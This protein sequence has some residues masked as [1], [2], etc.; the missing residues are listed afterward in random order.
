[1]RS[2]TTFVAV[3]LVLVNN[4][5]ILLARRCNTGFEDGNY[6]LVAGHAE[7]GE[8]LTLALLRE[9]KEEAGLTVVENSL[10]LVHVLHR[11]TLGDRVYVDF[12]YTCNEWLGEP[13]ICE[14]HLCDDLRWFA[15]ADLPNNMVGYV[16]QALNDIEQR[17]F[18]R[19]I[20]F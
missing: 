19:E 7:H 14:P 1:M 9:A 3:Y 8:R 11:R 16:R 6:S 17:V 10:S 2:P 18:H 5:Q 12:F 4:S 13:T 15:L 20:G